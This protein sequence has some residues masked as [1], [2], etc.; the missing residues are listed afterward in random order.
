MKKTIS[1]LLLVVMLTS[2]LSLTAHAESGIGIGAGDTVPDF[3]VE[4]TD[5]TTAT[6]SELL[7][8][9]DLVV[10]NLFASWCGPCKREFPEMDAVYQANKDRM[11]IIAVSADPADTM[12]V[13][14]DYKASNSLSF[15]MGL[16][17]DALPSL[18]VTSFP[19][20]LLIDRN[21][22]VGLVKAGAFMSKED[23]ESKVNYF[24][25]ENYSGQTLKT[26]RAFNFAPFVYGW[27]LLGGLLLLIGRW[28]IF[29]KAG[30]KGWHSLIPLLNSYDEYSTVWNGWLGVIA[31]LCIPIGLVCNVFKLPTFIYHVL[32]AASYL[33]GIPESLRLAKAFGKGKVFGVLLILP[34]FGSICRFLLGVG[35]AQFRPETDGTEA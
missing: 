3:T 30:K 21:G 24:L 6:L 33:I 11:E 26:E 2:L 22:K 14:A 32:I 16:R 18:T 4:L 31:A 28:G 35:R 12:E 23:F 7:K 5:G 13:I 20:T 27:V 10:L 19:T 15:P 29:R 17:G 1:I 8:E 9:K 34:V 25:S